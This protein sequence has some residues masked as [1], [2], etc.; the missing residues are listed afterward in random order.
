MSPT[1]AGIHTVAT[2]QITPSF[3]FDAY[4]GHILVASDI[5]FGTEEIQ[6][7][8]RHRIHG[9][10]RPGGIAVKTTRLSADHSRNGCKVAGRREHLAKRGLPFPDQ[11]AVNLRNF[12][13]EAFPEKGKGRSAGPYFRLRS[14]LT[15]HASR[16]LQ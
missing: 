11:A 8:F 2:L 6:I 16:S 7:H 13:H 9:K 15:S 14:E 10:A 5:F 3:A 4:G 12:L 1:Q